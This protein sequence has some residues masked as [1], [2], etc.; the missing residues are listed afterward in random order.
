[1]VE[2]E[3]TE[4]ELEGEGRAR[5]G[6][7]ARRGR[8]L[9]VVAGG[10]GGARVVEERRRC[11]MDLRRWKSAAATRAWQRELVVDSS[12]ERGRETQRTAIGLQ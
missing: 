3:E 4:D 11:T 2:V 5:L 10:L 1:M 12:G 7:G 6:G 9:A 8:Q